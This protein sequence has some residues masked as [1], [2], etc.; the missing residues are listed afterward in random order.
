MTYWLSPVGVVT[1]LFFSPCPSFSPETFCMVFVDFCVLLS[2]DKA[3]MAVHIQLWNSVLWH[4]VGQYMGTS[5]SEGLTASC[6]GC[7]M[8]TV[9]HFVTLM[10][11]YQSVWHHTLDWKVSVMKCLNLYVLTSTELKHFSPPVSSESVV[12]VTWSQ[13]WSCL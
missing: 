4:C 12:S 9:G 11:V 8:V 10:T 3:S 5:L 6:S 7:K 2:W 1:S 13:Y